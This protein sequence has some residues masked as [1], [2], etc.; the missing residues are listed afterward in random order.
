MNAQEYSWASFKPDQKHITNLSTGLDNGVV[1]GAGYGY[2]LN[3][4]KL[5]ILNIE[6]SLPAGKNLLDDHKIKLGGQMN[7][8]TFKN[9]RLTTKVYGIYRRYENSLVHMTNFGTY[10]G[11]NL[12]YYKE[13][14]FIA[15]EFGFDKA[16]VTYFNHSNNYKENFPDVID[17]WYEPATG[18]NYNY[19]LIVNYSFCK[20]NIY[21]KAGKLIAEDFKTDPFLPF[22]ATIGCNYIF[23]K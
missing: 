18:G 8:V 23:G 15:L 21:A 10:L 19:G 5:I 13:Q 22:Y 2:K 1:F 12:G 17:G 6:Y 11:G 3:I 16:I 20:L 4:K 14:F 9:F 7:V